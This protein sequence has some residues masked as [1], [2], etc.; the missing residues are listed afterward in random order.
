[1]AESSG[2][3]KSENRFPGRLIVV[4]DDGDFRQILEK[5]LAVAGYAVKGVATALEFYMEIGK[6]EYDLAILD[7][8]LPDQSGYV[9]AEY[10]R[11]NTGLRIVILSARSMIDERITGLKSGAD[12][13]LAKPVDFRELAASIENLLQRSPSKERS[14]QTGT[15]LSPGQTWRL[16][17]TEWALY[18]PEGE[19]VK[20]TSKEFEFVNCLAFQEGRIAARHHLLRILKYPNNQYGGRALESLV[21]RLRRKTAGKEESPIRTAHGT[22]YCFLP[23][24]SVD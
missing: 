21:H 3:M 17:R 20:L 19:R 14:E 9:L 15:A 8:G 13:Y 23:L 11:S 12:V 22:G 2:T 5:N 4:E 1:M 24:L 10:L 7:I 16:V 18:S 6:A